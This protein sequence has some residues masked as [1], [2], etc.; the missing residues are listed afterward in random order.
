MDS[1]IIA[2][3]EFLTTAVVIQSILL[4]ILIIFL[5]AFLIASM[6]VRRDRINV[7]LRYD[8]LNRAQLHEKKGEY[9]ELLEISEEHLKKYNNDIDAKWYNAIAL[10][11]LE[12]YSAALSAFTD[13]KEIDPIWQKEDVEDYIEVIRKHMDGPKTIAP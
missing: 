2:K 4:G 13:I 10:Y 7:E 5:I 6:I 12:K 3:L 9:K 1:E 8:F 11:K